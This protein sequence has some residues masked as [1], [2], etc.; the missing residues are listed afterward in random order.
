MEPTI[1]IVGHILSYLIFKV[2][3]VNIALSSA[4]FIFHRL[5]EPFHLTIGLGVKKA[6][7][8]MRYANLLKIALEIFGNKDWPIVGDQNRI[9]ARVFE[10]CSFQ[11]DFNIQGFN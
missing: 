8:T 3:D 2:L 1:I 10:P 4:R 9:D 6:G 5:E 7:S 11:E